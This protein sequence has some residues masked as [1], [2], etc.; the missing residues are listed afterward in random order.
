LCGNSQ[1]KDFAL[2]YAILSKS[3]RSIDVNNE[4]G[5]IDEAIQDYQTA[6]SLY[7]E[8]FESFVGL[9]QIEINRKNVD[10][11]CQYFKK[12]EELKED[13]ETVKKWLNKY[14]EE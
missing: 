9:G 3:A 5:N 7:D 4:L 10:L 11:A 1:A 13:S 2:F 6:I 8:R 14:C 12:A